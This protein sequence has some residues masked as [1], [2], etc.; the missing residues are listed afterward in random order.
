MNQVLERFDAVA[1]DYRSFT[2]KIPKYDR[3]LETIVEVFDQLNRERTPRR[4]ADLG[5]GAGTLAEVVLDRYDPAVFHGVDGVKSM[6]EQTRSRLGEPGETEVHLEQT[7]F[8]TWEPD[9]SYDWIYS[10]LSIH[11]LFDSEK[12]SLYGRVNNALTEGG[13]FLLSDLVR[14]P[15][16]RSELY[17]A[18]YRDRLSDLGFTDEE[19]DE[20]LRR[21][22]ENDV[23][24]EL[25]ATLRWLREL[26]FGT[27]ECVWKDFN[28]AIILAS[29]GPR[30]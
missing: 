29:K 28:R 5:V 8:E 1:E 23:P 18:V 12:R 24:G 3:I 30:S 22:H 6:I 21:H 15:G 20:R 10:N 26:G 13:T 25:R 19:I 9:G 11:H 16:K 2:D 7:T 14:T 4:V 17:E 27:V